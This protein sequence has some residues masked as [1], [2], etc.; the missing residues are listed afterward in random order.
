V[1]VLR[2]SFDLFDVAIYVF[3]GVLVGIFIGQRL[4]RRNER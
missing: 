4:E 3:I 2:A 1:S